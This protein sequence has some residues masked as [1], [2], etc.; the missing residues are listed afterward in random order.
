ML[1]FTQ[2]PDNCCQAAKEHDSGVSS[3]KDI[4]RGTLRQETSSQTRVV[5]Y[6]IC[7]LISRHSHK[8]VLRTQTVWSVPAAG[9]DL[10]TKAL[11]K[12]CL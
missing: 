8:L 3:N 1:Q 9:A 4:A 7:A 6:S 11:R 2:Q 5:F 12:V 10:L